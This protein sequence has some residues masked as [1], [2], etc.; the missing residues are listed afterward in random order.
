M[1]AQWFGT[2]SGELACHGSWTPPFGQA[3]S[4]L[5]HTLRMFLPPTLRVLPQGPLKL[6]SPHFFPL[7]L[8][9]FCPSCLD[10]LAWEA[11]PTAPGWSLW[12][13]PNS[14][15]QPLWPLGATS[16]LICLVSFLS[17][18][19]LLVG[20]TQHLF[21]SVLLG[22]GPRWLE[23]RGWL[24]GIEGTNEW[25]VSEGLAALISHSF[26]LASKLF[27]CKATSKGLYWCFRNLALSET[28][29][30]TQVPLLPPPAS[31]GLAWG[32]SWSP[33]QALYMVLII[34][35][36]GPVSEISPVGDGQ[37]MLM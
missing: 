14:P 9:L 28:D 6:L 24:T 15:S 30:A 12:S 18:H 11:F 32:S 5:G 37:H 3:I 31:K 25:D 2:V 27:C 29:E 13:P 20:R 21:N 19:D 17:D 36:D 35:D 26:E 8:L 7:H 10:P 1:S 16:L 4:F 23:P 34:Y 22:F 33:N